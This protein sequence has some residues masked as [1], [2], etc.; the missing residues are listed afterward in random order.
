MTVFIPRID[1]QDFAI[2]FAR[3]AQQSVAPTLELQFFTAQN[4]IQDRMDK[5]IAKLLAG[6]ASTT[7]ETAHLTRRLAALTPSLAALEPFAA[8]TA[9]NESLLKSVIDGLGELSALADPSTAADFDAKRTAILILLDKM[10]TAGT[11]PLGMIHD[12][13]RQARTD[14]VAALEG[15]V[16][17][18]FAA[19]ADVTAAVD[20]I[21]ALSVTLTDRLTLVE[22]AA[23]TAANGVS[24]LNEVKVRVES[25]IRDIEAAA[26]AELSKKVAD[27]Q[28]YYGRILTSLSL[29]LDGAISLTA[30]FA[31][32]INPEGPPQTGTVIDYLA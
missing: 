7:S 30:S 18:G 23:E 22:L 25:E 32:S 10:Q 28:S 26:R 31:D 3:T 4:T 6:G 16:T 19:P 12:G 21:D 24:A 1:P 14:A 15:I 27:A 29:S 11:P 2:S 9:A 8:R 20:A 17:N 13:L 5:D